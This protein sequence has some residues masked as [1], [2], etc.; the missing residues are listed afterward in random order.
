MGIGK[1]RLNGNSSSQVQSKKRRPKPVAEGSG[2]DVLLSEVKNLIRDHV[3]TDDQLSESRAGSLPTNSLPFSRFDE[4][5]VTIDELSSTGKNPINNVHIP[6]LLF[7]RRPWSGSKQ[8]TCCRRSFHCSW[9]HM[10][11]PDLQYF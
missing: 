6:N 7:R 11:C 4:I 2:E 8:S 5:E 9:R 3:G 10:R 1:H